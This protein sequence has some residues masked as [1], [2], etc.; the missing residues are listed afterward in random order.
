[1]RFLAT[2]LMDRPQLQEYAV[3]IVRKLVLSIILGVYS[4]SG[5]IGVAS[6]VA[7]DSVTQFTASVPTAEGPQ[8]IQVVD[9]DDPVS[10]VA[11]S[12]NVTVASRY[13][14]QGVDQIDGHAALQPNA[15]LSFYDISASAWANWDLATGD[16]NEVDLTLQIAREAGPWSLA[17]GYIHLSYPNREDWVPS[18]EVFADVSVGFPLNP[19]VSIHYDF[20]AGKGSYSTVEVSQA[21][22]STVSVAGRFFCQDHYYEL[23]GIPALELNAG[24]AFPLWGL[25]V[26]SSVSRFTTWENGH[27]RDGAAV[28]GAW[29]F[30]FDLAREF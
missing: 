22:G 13:F 3:H 25:T 8:T 10:P 6:E 9:G 17:T 21:L 26:T 24:A 11:V 29:L 18:Q 14:L 2:F 1:M 4:A 19:S 28:P 30:T 20:D 23:S 7:P 5:S 15:S 16:L 12:T 27:F